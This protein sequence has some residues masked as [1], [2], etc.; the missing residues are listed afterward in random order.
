MLLS[1]KAR[2]LEFEPRMSDSQIPLERQLDPRR[3]ENSHVFAPH[4]G[5][6]CLGLEQWSVEVSSCEKQWAV[7]EEPQTLGPASLLCVRKQ[8]FK[9]LM[10]SES[11]GS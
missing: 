11:K 10:N 2:R 9:R 5:G 3:T 1:G 4:Q 8:A 6:S 7:T